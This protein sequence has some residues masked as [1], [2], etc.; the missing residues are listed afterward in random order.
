MSLPPFE[1]QVL[2]ADVLAAGFGSESSSQSNYVRCACA[3]RNDIYVGCADGAVLRFSLPQLENGLAES[4]M[5]LNRHAFPQGK[6]IDDIK[7]IPSIRKILVQTDRRIYFFTYPD[8]DPIPPDK[9]PPL[10]NVVT[11][12]L[13]ERPPPP[14]KP[15]QAPLAAEILVVKPKFIAPYVI[16]DKVVPRP[17]MG[18]PETSKPVL[19]RRYGDFVCIG[20]TQLYRMVDLDAKLHFE[21]VQVSQSEDVSEKPTPS[22]AVLSKNEFLLVTWSGTASFGVSLMGTGDPSRNPI[23]YKHQLRSLAVDYPHIIAIT[24]NQTILVRSIDDPVEDPDTFSYLQTFQPSPKLP[25]PVAILGTQGD[26][27][28]PYNHGAL[29]LEQVSFSLPLSDAGNQWGD[30]S[31]GVRNAPVSPQF[32]N[33][34]ILVLG[35]NSI[36]ALCAPPVISR[37]ESLIESNQI[38]Q[39]VALLDEIHRQ[40]NSTNPP[41]PSKITEARYLRQKLGYRCLSLCSFEEAG[42]QL[43]LGRLDPR[44]LIRYFP[45]IVGSLFEVSPYATNY[46]GLKP[47]VPETDIA[48]L[49]RNYSPHLEPN[50]RTAHPTVEL[51]KV[52][53]SQAREMLLEYLSKWRVQRRANLIPEDHDTPFIDVA[54][55][56]VLL[57]LF[58]ED[59][60]EE[61]LGS[62]LQESQNIN[63]GDVEQTLIDMQQFQILCSLYEQHG[64]EAKLIE[65]WAKLVEGEWKD[66]RIADPLQRIGSLLSK[67]K[68]R[69]LFKKHIFWLTKRDLDFGLKLLTSRDVQK[70]GD[71]DDASTLSQLRMLSEEAADLFLE[72]IVLQKR[73]DD[74]DIHTRLAVR[75]L[76][77][78][79]RALPN[80]TSELVTSAPRGMTVLTALANVPDSPLKRLRF[81]TLL[82]LQGS[83]RYDFHEVRKTLQN[84]RDLL[85]IEMTLV[86]GKLALH[87]EA[88]SILVHELNDPISAQLY[89]T[90]GGN[91]IPENL[92]NFVASQLDLQ[93]WSLYMVSQLRAAQKLPQSTET[94]QGALL[95]VLFGVLLTTPNAREDTAQ[96]LDTQGSQLDA[97]HVVSTAPPDWPVSVL[98]SFLSRSFAQSF[99]LKCEGQILK[100]LSTGQNLEVAERTWMLEQELGYVIEEPDEEVGPEVEIDEKVLSEKTGVDDLNPPPDEIHPSELG[101]GYHLDFR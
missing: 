48:D 79:L 58:A 3:I 92:A 42:R 91:I 93:P 24:A 29:R 59:R 31:E 83:S 77:R 61:E 10:K 34:R 36:Q 97:E 62:L 47:D 21:I 52:L 86:D 78:V 7:V 27:F 99:H 73:S 69:V 37:A 12:C 40:A 66:P 28:V 68:D 32:E 25:L 43:F 87:E 45:S 90:K 16:G 85:Q 8:L 96:L 9:M 44:L 55:D 75:L 33:S 54:V 35:D 94:E 41:D 49:V 60:K 26:F 84:A 88:L 5:L 57:R 4:Y 22:L 100:A 63:L 2:I 18:F 82:F 14:V 1:L 30:Q 19:A 56:T 39:S 6:A 13:D 70:S 46:I 80:A 51:R 20:D 38:E 53:N 72:H 74:A 98:S 81:K 95:R 64:N 89:C 11:F 65:T 17:D 67:T 15:G 101:S 71:F 76:H 23:E 50:T